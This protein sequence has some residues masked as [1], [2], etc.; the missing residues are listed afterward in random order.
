MNRGTQRCSVC[1]TED[2]TLLN[3]LQI[4]NSSARFR[5]VGDDI[6]RLSRFWILAFFCLEINCSKD[7]TIYCGHIEDQQ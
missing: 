5:T 6:T 4:A 2:T 3:D 1:S 7:S